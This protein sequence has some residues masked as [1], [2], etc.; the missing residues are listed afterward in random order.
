LK[1]RKKKEELIGKGHELESFLSDKLEDYSDKERVHFYHLILRAQDFL[2]DEIY[3]YADLR[4]EA[5]ERFGDW[6]DAI[7]REILNEARKRG[8]S[9][10]KFPTASRVGK[11]WRAQD[12]KPN[13][14]MMKKIYD[15]N[16]RKYDAVKED[17]WWSIYLE[18]EEYEEYD[19]NPLA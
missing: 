17:H 8:I 10:V 13:M 14:K 19:I 9:K 7:V 2:E 1:E 18:E 5:L 16:L 15:K 12:D 3:K 6:A 4:D 11:F